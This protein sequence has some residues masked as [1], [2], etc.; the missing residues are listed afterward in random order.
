M[1][2]EVKWIKG[3]DFMDGTPRYSFEGRD[4]EVTVSDIAV[5][6]YGQKERKHSHDPKSSKTYY[7]GYVRN[8]K[9]ETSDTV[10]RF[11]KLT[12]AKRET[13]NLFNR[14]CELYPEHT[15]AW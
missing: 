6:I 3:E 15:E 11:E 14:Y 12:D 13:L 8:D 9:V 10:G 5:V 4:P 2:N 1:K 7:Y